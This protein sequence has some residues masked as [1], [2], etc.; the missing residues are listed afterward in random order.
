MTRWS[1][2]VSIT[3]QEGLSVRRHSRMVRDTGGKSSGMTMGHCC[4]SS[5][6]LKDEFM[7]LPSSMAGAERL[8]GRTDLYTEQVMTSG[9]GNAGKVSLQCPKSTACRTALPTDTSGGWIPISAVLITNATGAR[10]STTESSAGGTIEENC[11]EDIRNSGSMATRL[12]RISTSKQ[13]SRTKHSRRFGQ[14]IT[15][16]VG[17]FRRQF[18]SCCCGRQRLNSKN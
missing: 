1:V 6:I 3:T 18:K 7:A 15:P 5:H 13:P 2:D 11:I 8:L 10:E 12:P 4:P 16:H 14:K 17:N 9:A